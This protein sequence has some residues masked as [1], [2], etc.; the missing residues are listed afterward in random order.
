MKNSKGLS[1][2]VESRNASGKKDSK[3]YRFR[4]ILIRRRGHSSQPLRALGSRSG[5]IICFGYALNALKAKTKPGLVSQIGKA[6]QNPSSLSKPF[7]RKSNTRCKRGSFHGA[8][9][10]I[11]PSIRQSRMETYATGEVGY[12]TGCAKFYGHGMYFRIASL[13]SATRGVGPVLPPRRAA[14]PN[15]QR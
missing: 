13:A 15:P 10:R 6:G 3:V 5:A 2:S 4:E 14:Y 12:Q 9:A 8:R 1:A 7:P 11:L